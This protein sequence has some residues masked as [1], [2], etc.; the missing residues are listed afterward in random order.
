VIRYHC[1]GLPALAPDP[2]PIVQSCQ[3]S[4]LGNSP[5]L[6][7]PAQASAPAAL[8]RPHHPSPG[9]AGPVPA[10][11]RLVPRS[12]ISSKS[13]SPLR[14]AC[15]GGEPVPAPS[16]SGLTGAFAC[17]WRRLDRS[18]WTSCPCSGSCLPSCM[19]TKTEQSTGLLLREVETK[20]TWSRAA[21][22]AGACPMTWRQSVREKEL[23]SLSGSFS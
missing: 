11:A 13:T 10:A 9:A 22:R 18:K 16:S 20:I 19:A 12:P 21:H 17:H 23:V 8:G 4:N 14:L 5:T 1:D 2:L 7:T 6:A 3:S 15:Q